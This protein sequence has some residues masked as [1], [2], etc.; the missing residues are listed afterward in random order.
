MEDTILGIKM[1]DFKR[2]REGMKIWITCV[3]KG[4]T[5]S[6]SQYIRSVF[7]VDIIAYYNV[8]SQPDTSNPH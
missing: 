7:S 1:M 3:D 2:F 8:S 5:K 4:T 6:P